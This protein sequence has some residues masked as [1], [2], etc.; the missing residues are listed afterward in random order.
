M[1]IHF[2]T[3]DVE[4]MHDVDLSLVSAIRQVQCNKTIY[5]IKYAFYMETV[6]VDNLRIFK[7]NYLFLYT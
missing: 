1:I 4:Y 5:T 7:N 3:N 6:Q 2:I